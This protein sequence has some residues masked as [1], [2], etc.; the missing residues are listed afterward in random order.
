MHKPTLKDNTSDLSI[1]AQNPTKG[2]QRCLGW[3]FELT[4]GLHKSLSVPEGLR[5]VATILMKLI[6]TFHDAI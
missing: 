2:E 6:W 3:D 5:I 4:N 1:W